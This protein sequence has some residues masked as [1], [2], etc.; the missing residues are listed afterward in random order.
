MIKYTKEYCQANKVAIKVNNK[1]YEEL[2]KFLNC[3]NPE[4]IIFFGYAVLYDT[5]SYDLRI[6]SDKWCDLHLF[7]IIDF[8]TFIQDN[9]KEQFPKDDFGIIVENKNGKEIIEYLISK[10]F[11]NR[12]FIGDAN[13]KEYY[14]IHINKNKIGCGYT[15]PTSKT[16]TLQQLKNLENNM[17]KK[18]I[19]YKAPYDLFEGK[20]NKGILY[21]KN[22]YALNT[23]YPQEY[24]KTSPYILPKEIV[25]TW[26]AVYEPEKPKEFLIKIND[27]FELRVI[28]EGI[29]YSNN[30]NITSFVGE[31][32]S[33]LSNFN[34]KYGDTSK[35]K[36]KYDCV[37]EDIIFSKTGC[38]DSKSSIHTW[39]NVWEKYQEL[40]K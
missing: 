34:K 19:G 27:S 22:D 8:Q 2:I 20:I 26:E 36:V 23:Y 16:Y 15:N 38:Q 4:T 31:M 24:S 5:S 17:E 39:I 3:K 21:K 11:K 29:F 35:K 13:N 18:I 9:M 7:K 32:V 12:G 33:N 6:W 14:F 40:N 25:E 30:E 10:G 37:I 28:K 1:E